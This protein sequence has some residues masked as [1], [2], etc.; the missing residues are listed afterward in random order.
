LQAFHEELRK[1][2]GPQKGAVTQRGISGLHRLC[3]ADTVVKSRKQ[4]WPEVLSNCGLC[5]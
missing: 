5:Y 2:S 1:T 4:N 3:K